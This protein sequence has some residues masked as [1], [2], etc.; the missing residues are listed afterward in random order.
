M[1][2]LLLITMLMAQVGSNSQELYKMQNGAHSGISSF[3]N[4][5]GI[6][7]S[8]G[9]TNMSA[10]G[11]A[12]ESLKARQQKVLLDIKGA[13]VI[14]R[15]WCTVNDRSEK[16][17]RT[18][19][20]QM[21]W[22]NSSKPAVDVPLGDFFGVGLGKTAAFQSALFSNPEGRSFNCFIPM[23]FKTGAKVIIQ[24]E[25]DVDLPLLFFDIDYI[26]LDRPE[27]NMLYFHSYWNRKIT[28]PMEEDYEFLPKVIGKGRFLGVNVGVNADSI[29]EDTWWGEGEVKMYLDGDTKY[30]T[31][32]GTGTEDY[33]GT[34]W[35][36]GVY[37]HMYQGCT[38]ADEK[39][40]K[41]TFYRFH[42]PDQI[43][44]HSDIRVTIQKI[45]G[46]DRDLV[47]RLD[48]KGVKLKPVSVATDTGFLRLFEVKPP[49]SLQ[50]NNFPK[51]WVN[52]Y[53]IDDY[54][55]TAYFYLDKPASNL[56]AI[57]G[58]DYRTR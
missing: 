33:I 41:Y 13:G 8:G 15:I 12:F 25:G 29:Y 27:A 42:I 40:K 44:F 28:S 48:Q 32:N 52:F 26:K 11:N 16:M 45:G 54:S 30:P 37:T 9:K 10:K 39:G 20:L 3:E 35:G 47:R 19:R 22:D 31:L 46:G 14:Q 7:G 38:I 58:V 43:F 4:L 6:K 53:R 34:G 5:N 49:I 57:A 24:N 1:R 55:S 36:Q 56:P 50:Q 23:P 2:Y 17:L 21:F 18:L 51:G